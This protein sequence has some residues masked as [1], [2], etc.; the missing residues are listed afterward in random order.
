MARWQE[1][2]RGQGVGAGVADEGAVETEGHEV[3]AG[4]GA[5]MVVV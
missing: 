5:C 2:Q 1:E 4:A 3:G